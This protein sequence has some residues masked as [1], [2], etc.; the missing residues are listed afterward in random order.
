[1]T[2]RFTYPKFFVNKREVNLSFTFDEKG[3]SHNRFIFDFEVY[4]AFLLNNK[5]KDPVFI[6]A[7]K[8]SIF[9]RIFKKRKI[10][11]NEEF[12]AELLRILS[13]EEEDQEILEIIEK[14]GIPEETYKKIHLLNRQINETYKTDI[15]SDQSPQNAPRFLESINTPYNL[16]A[17]K[18]C[19]SF[20]YFQDKCVGILGKIFQYIFTSVMPELITAD[21][22]QENPEIKSPPFNVRIKIGNAIWQGEEN[23]AIIDEEA[24]LKEMELRGLTISKV[25]DLNNM[26][27]GYH[28]TH[29]AKYIVIPLYLSGRKFFEEFII[30][31]ALHELRHYEQLPR[32]KYE[33]DM[34]KKMKGKP[35]PPTS[36]ILYYCLFEIMKELEAHLS[37]YTNTEK[38]RIDIDWIRTFKMKLYRLAQQKGEFMQLQEYYNNELDNKFDIMFNSMIM[39]YLI[40][41]ANAVNENHPE[42]IELYNSAGKRIGINELDNT[43]TNEKFFYIGKVPDIYITQTIAQTSS[44]KNIS[45]FYLLYNKACDIL[46]INKDNMLINMEDYKNLWRYAGN[47]DKEQIEA[48][49]AKLGV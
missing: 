25:S 1:L 20:R 7:L 4:K 13:F 34:L 45:K 24:A 22:Q 46:K 14:L 18:K 28:G 27:I 37:E 31:C 21:V 9:G 6:D 44:I 30:K 29:I 11:T 23:I 42:L 38:R 15:M 12:N 10:M 35:L 19:P 16:I 43:L 3:Y 48:K 8:K 17:A 39:G 26:Y 40:S 33:F 36:R 41:F 49:N 2:K 32:T 47:K 5:I